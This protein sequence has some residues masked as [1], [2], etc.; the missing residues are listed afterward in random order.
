M[1]CV[2]CGADGAAAFCRQC[3]K[4]QDADAPIVASLP[5]ARPNAWTNQLQYRALL[6]Y[7][8]PRARI[9][10][11]SKRAKTGISGE[12]V[13][14]VLDAVIPSPIAL[15]KVTH[16]MVP[17]VDRLGIRTKNELQAVWQAQPGRVL[18]GFV[19]SLA[20]K[21]LSVTD[22]EQEAAE[23]TLSANVPLG[24]FTNPGVVN[25]KFETQSGWVRGTFRITIAGQWY[26]WGKSKRLLEELVAG[27]NHDLADQTGDS[28]IRYQRVA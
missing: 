24:I 14:A 9:R 23:C 17:I 15:S 18:L 27:I 6:E 8:E 26:D 5:P 25:A 2:H 3:G 10:A 13:L 12:D 22:V 19:C 16:V 21:S 20:T 1:Y 28:Q 4:S 11:A 7:D